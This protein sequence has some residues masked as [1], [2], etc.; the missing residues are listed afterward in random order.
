MDRVD[1]PPLLA[2]FLK[3]PGG[4]AAAKR[5]RQ[6]RSGVIIGISEHYPGEAEHEVQLLEIAVLAPLAPRVARR[7]GTDRALGRQAGKERV[8]EI[9]KTPVLEISSCCENHP[10][11]AVVV[12]QIP[13]HRIAAQF[14]DN[15]RSSE[16]VAPNALLRTG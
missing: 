4:H 13:D 1:E 7:L 14:A 11:R 15:L 8:C 10:P 2:N 16:H 6:D 9:D 3:Q 12:A 5:G